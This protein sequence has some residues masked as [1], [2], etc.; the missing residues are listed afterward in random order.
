MFIPALQIVPT[1]FLEEVLC[2]SHQCFPQCP[3]EESVLYSLLG[4]ILKGTNE[5]SMCYKYM[6]TFISP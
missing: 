1:V 6:P 3:G 5:W 2:C 4:K